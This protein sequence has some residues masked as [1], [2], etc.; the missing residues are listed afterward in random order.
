M[1]KWFSGKMVKEL[2]KTKEKSTSDTFITSLI[3]IVQITWLVYSKVHEYTYRQTDTFCKSL[4]F[5][6]R[7]GKIGF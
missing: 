2:V 4:N 5:W 7:M 1:V 3:K 6:I